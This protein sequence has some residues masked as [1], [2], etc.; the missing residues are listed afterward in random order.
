MN[1]GFLEATEAKDAIVCYSISENRTI[2]LIYIYIQILNYEW[3]G[4]FTKRDYF[5]SG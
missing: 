1:F 2:R 3:N 5:V 4:Y